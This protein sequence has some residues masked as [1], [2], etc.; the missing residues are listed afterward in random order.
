MLGT[1]EFLRCDTKLNAGP[2]L[3]VALRLGI[4]RDQPIQRFS[5]HFRQERKPT[6]VSAKQ[7]SGW[8]RIAD[9]PMRPAVSFGVA[10]ITHEV[11]GSSSQRY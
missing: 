9:F 11:L 4:L 7:V 6:V 1:I 8:E 10:P 5:C 3:H 2:Y